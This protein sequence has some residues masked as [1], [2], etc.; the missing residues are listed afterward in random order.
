MKLYIDID[1]KASIAAGYEAPASSAVYELPVETIPAQLR[2]YIAPYW[3]PATGRLKAE[4]E[5]QPGDAS[6]RMPHPLTDASVLAAL[7]QWQAWRDGKALANQERIT[8]EQQRREA[9]DLATLRERRT[10]TRWDIV[11]GEKGDYEFANFC[12]EWSTHI[13]KTPEALQWLAELEA[14]RMAQAARNRQQR[15][16]AEERE[17]QIKKE[18]ADDTAALIS[19][20]GEDGELAQYTD[21]MMAPARLKAILRTAI[22]RLAPLVKWDD[23]LSLDEREVDSAPLTAAQYAA[24]RAILDKLKPNESYQ[25]VK[26]TVAAKNTDDEVYEPAPREST[27]YTVRVTHAWRSL[28]LDREY[29]LD[30]S[31]ANGK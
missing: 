3:D 14:G 20:Y 22:P 2:A 23:E 9:D 4:Y 28:R 21:G 27:I 6:L 5:I 30:P 12:R 25:L 16:A 31:P 29:S 18:R 19:E 8:R 10:R 7:C 17:A 11:D 26:Y 1:Q 13:R 24:L 15:L